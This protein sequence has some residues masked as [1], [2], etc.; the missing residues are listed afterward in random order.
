M[1]PSFCIWVNRKNRGWKSWDHPVPI[2]KFSEFNNITSLTKSSVKTKPTFSSPRNKLCNPVG[3]I[4]KE[5]TCYANLILQAL[6]TVLVLWSSLLLESSITSPISKATTWIMLI[7]KKNLKPI[8]PPNF[9]RAL[10]GKMAG[11]LFHFNFQQ[12]ALEV[13]QV[14]F[15]NLKGK[16]ILANDFASRKQMR[17][18]TCSCVQQYKNVLDKFLNSATDIVFWKI[19]GFVLPVIPLLKPTW[20]QQ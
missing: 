20:K 17:H 18:V 2:A 5:N 9:L 3:F 8:H 16:S 15:D 19:N 7:Q 14:V 13:L 11:I 4:N 10:T 12:D 6:S 1:K